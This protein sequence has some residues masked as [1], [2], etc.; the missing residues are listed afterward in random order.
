MSITGCNQG[1]GTVTDT[2]KLTLRNKT[3]VKNTRT[4]VAALQA[5]LTLDDASI[6]DAPGAAITAS[7]GAPTIT[8]TNAS[9]TNGQNVAITAPIYSG[10]RPTLTL[11]NSK[12]NA[13]Q[14][15]VFLNYGGTVVIT[16]SE[17]NDNGS[18]GSCQSS[19]HFNDVSQ[20]SSLLLR[21][22]S[23]QRNCS[24]GIELDGAAASTFD[25]GRGDDLGGNTI[26]GNG[27]AGTN[28]NLLLDANAALTVY[29]AGN[30]WDAGVQG[31]APVGSV[32][33]LPGRFAVVTGNTLD[34]TGVQT[35][36]NF[37]V[38]GAGAALTVLRLAENACVPQ[39]GCT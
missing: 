37:E 15:G 13:N 17:I 9:V 19:L 29:A 1:A 25:L 22:T 35:G 38:Q 7:S 20:V 2:A 34:L 8:L 24:T 36:K 32:T 33:P 21:G 23:I 12:L 5:Q 10:A 31:A 18:T 27:G 11:T 4:L 6:E 28:P 30:T 3:L 39:G 14:G 26:A 16:G